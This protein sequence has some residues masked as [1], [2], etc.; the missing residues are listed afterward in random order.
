M[1]VRSLVVTDYSTGTQYR[2]SGQDGTWQ[3]IEAVGGAVNPSGGGGGSGSRVAIVQGPAVTESPGMPVP[4]AGTHR[5]TTRVI[6]TPGLGDYTVGPTSI[7]PNTVAATNYP[8][9]PAGWVVTSSGKVLPP[10]SAPV[11]KPAPCA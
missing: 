4:F 1:Q 3:S 9:L 10:N 7:D 2:Y 8:G 6:V 11:S 5:D